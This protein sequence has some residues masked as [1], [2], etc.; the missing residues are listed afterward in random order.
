MRRVA[1]E[2]SNKIEFAIFYTFLQVSIDFG[3]LSYF[4]EFY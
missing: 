4:W 3:S 2:E 1:Q